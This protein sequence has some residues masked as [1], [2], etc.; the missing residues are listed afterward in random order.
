MS[1]LNALDLAFIVDTT[2]S[3]GRLIGAAQQQMITMLNALTQAADVEIRLGIVEYR[4]HPPQDKLV[5]RAYPFT[6]NLQQAQAAINKLKAEGGGDGPESVLDGV[7]TACKKLQWR[8]HARRIAVLVGDAPPH[9]VGSGGDGFPQG[10]PCGETIESVTAAA[11]EARITLYALG[12]TRSVT[13]SFSRLSNMTGGEFFEAGQGDKAIERLKAI[14]VNEFG[15]L[16]FDRR[17]L[18]EQQANPDASIDDLVERLA[19]SRPAVSA[20]LSRLGARGLL[21]WASTTC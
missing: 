5:S 9:G 13:D 19:S 21:T 11:E 17:V 8:P 14:L 7:T 15:N 12:L 10:C 2:G 3:M 4:D 1:E 16:D 20:A 6:S 18:A